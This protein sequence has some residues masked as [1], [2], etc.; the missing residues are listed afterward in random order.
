MLKNVSN[1]EARAAKSRTMYFFF[2][3]VLTR[4]QIGVFFPIM[5]TTNR[6]IRCIL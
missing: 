1:I 5:G 3:K 2:H 4:I 6:T